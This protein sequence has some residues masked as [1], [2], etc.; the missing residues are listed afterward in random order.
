MRRR[1]PTPW[2]VVVGFLQMFLASHTESSYASCGMVCVG[3]DFW[4]MIF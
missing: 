3:D 1:V 4:W 2:P